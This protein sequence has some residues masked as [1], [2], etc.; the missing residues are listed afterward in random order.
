M[1][2]VDKNKEHSRVFRYS[3]SRL[4][5]LGPQSLDSEKEKIKARTM[6]ICLIDS[7]SYDELYLDLQKQ[8]DWDDISTMAYFETTVMYE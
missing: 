7:S 1:D 8:N 6:K 2:K 4:S 5:F 3:K